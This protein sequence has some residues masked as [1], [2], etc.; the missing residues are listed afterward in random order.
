MKARQLH[1]CEAV[2]QQNETLQHPVLHQVT[3]KYSAKSEHNQVYFI[4]IRLSYF[5]INQHFMQACGQP[6]PSGVHICKF[7]LLR[8]GKIATAKL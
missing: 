8:E 4:N 7:D 1:N 3:I 6:L 5:R 2:A